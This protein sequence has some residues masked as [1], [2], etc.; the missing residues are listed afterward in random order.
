MAMKWRRNGKL[1]M[2][3]I[4]AY[5]AEMAAALINISGGAG[6][7]REENKYWREIKCLNVL[8]GISGIEAWLMASASAAMA[9]AAASAVAALIWRRGV[10]WR[11]S[12]MACQYQSA[13]QRLAA[14]LSSGGGIWYAGVSAI[15]I[16]GGMAANGGVAA[17]T[18]RKRHRRKYLGGGGE[19]GKTEI[20]G[21]NES[22]W[23]KPAWHVNNQPA[24]A[25]S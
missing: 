5:G 10:S 21:G 16:N 15:S 25:I 7:C 24:A 2:A 9:S 13:S 4:V 20:A 19:C 1:C 8:S 14:G 6:G 12:A 23:R 17:K 18:Q 11:L 22:V 3:N